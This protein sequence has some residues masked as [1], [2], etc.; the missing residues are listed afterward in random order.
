MW[1]RC[2]SRLLYSSIA[3]PTSFCDPSPRFL[4]AQ[5]VEDFS[6][7][8]HDANRWIVTAY[9]ENSGGQCDFGA[10]RYGKRLMDCT[11]NILTSWTGR[12]AWSPLKTDKD[13]SCTKAAAAS[14]TPAVA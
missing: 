12:A 5:F 13:S 10:S 8:H 4:R 14:A 7:E 1:P 11:R 6:G 2:V 9:I 3:P